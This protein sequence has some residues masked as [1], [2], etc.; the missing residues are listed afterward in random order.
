MYSSIHQYLFI[1]FQ[2]LSIVLADRDNIKN[3]TDMD[4]AW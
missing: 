2:V 3:K 4:C 1:A